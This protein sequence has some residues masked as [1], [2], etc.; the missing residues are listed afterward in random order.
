MTFPILVGAGAFA[1]GGF[2]PGVFAIV[3]AAVC[4]T[5]AARLYRR[6]RIEADERVSA[7]ASEQF[8]R[9]WL[10]M[11]AAVAIGVA[12]TFASAGPK[13]GAVAVALWVA[14]VASGAGVLAVTRHRGE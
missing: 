9:L 3:L 2:G 12:T 4:T 13:A 14:L 8:R 7:E 5:M 11:L 6:W 1:L 10:V